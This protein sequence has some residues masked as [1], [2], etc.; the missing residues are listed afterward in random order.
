MNPYGPPNQ[1]NPPEPQEPRKPQ[2]LHE[3]QRE[4][5]IIVAG[6][7]VVIFL[8][9]LMYGFMPDD[10]GNPRNS[11]PALTLILLV[12][13]VAIGIYGGSLIKVAM[14][15]QKKYED[16]TI[17]H[18]PIEFATLD[19]QAREAMI[20]REHQR[21]L[22]SMRH[23][24]E[25]RLQAMTLPSTLVMI[26]GQLAAEDKLAQYASMLKR[27]QSL[28]D[29]VVADATKPDADPAA[30]Q[31][32]IEKAVGSILDIIARWTMDK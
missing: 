6:V 11:D 29:Q 30:A 26:Q 7:G 32:T 3:S 12:V 14:E 27:S 9:G 16:I 5:G 25:L 23:P 2:L 4:I 8:F 13:G 28:I 31:I 20:Q 10:Y 18:K 21:L 17:F 22:L 1:P 15:R 19:H 24:H